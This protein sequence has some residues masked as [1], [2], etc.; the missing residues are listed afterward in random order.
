MTA[1]VETPTVSSQAPAAC[2]RCDAE[3][4]PLSWA[5]GGLLACS[6]CLPLVEALERKLQAET[7][8]LD[9]AIGEAE[10]RGD[11]RRWREVLAEGVA[12]S[13]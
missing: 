12:P 2:A 8:R 6:S 5:R 9:G 11:A 10:R 3:N 4:V 1:T 13:G 7:E